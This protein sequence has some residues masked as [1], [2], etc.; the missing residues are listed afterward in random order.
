LWD[1]SPFPSGA[2]APSTYNVTTVGA[3]ERFFRT[4]RILAAR[5]PT[6]TPPPSIEHMFD[7][8]T[9]TRSGPTPT[10]TP[11]EVEAL[12]RRVADLVGLLNATTADLV[13]VVAEVLASG[14]WQQEGIRSPAHWL[15]WQAGV[16]LRRA[17]RLVGI[18][19]RTA[20]LPCT[21][22]AFT[23]GSLSE[24]QVAEITA[25]VPAAHDAELASFATSAT[26]SQLHKVAREHLHEPVAEGP[27]DQDRN[28]VVFGHGDD[29]RW[30]LRADLD[31]SLGALVQRG[32]EACRD[33][34][35]H[36]RHPEA[37]QTPAR[38]G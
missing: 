21:T 32:L 15:A 37:D 5:D 33:T 3:L 4:L 31:A 22:A 13:A 28:Q 1:A 8:A 34:E 20:E 11:E 35:F 30:R 26:V 29:G 36:A 6:V 23:A 17:R 10:A 38:S 7:A 16:S 24:D 9:E 2:L 18:A 19:Q 27:P 14:A 12:E 25:T